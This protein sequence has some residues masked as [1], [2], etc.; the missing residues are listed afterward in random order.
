M[1]MRE[2]DERKE[3]RMVLWEWDKEMVEVNE[4]ERADGVSR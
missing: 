2:G 3:G 1:L 4:M